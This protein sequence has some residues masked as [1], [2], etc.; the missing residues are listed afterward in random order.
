MEPLA[1]STPFSLE[2][3]M[4]R[5]WMVVGFLFLMSLLTIID[6]VCVSAAKAEM[7]ADL[8]IDD[9]RFG[10]VFSSFALGYALFQMPGGWFVDR[11]GARLFLTFVV[12]AWSVCTGIT[13]TV[14]ALGPL[15]VI[16]FV[17][18]GFEAGAYPAAARACY[19]WLNARQ[20]GVAQGILMSGSRL[21]AAFGL[22]IIAWVIER[23]GWRET[24]YVLG[25]VGLIWAA[26]WYSWF[27]EG[28][29]GSEALNHTLDWSV[30]RKPAVPGLLAQYFSSNFTIFLCFTWLLPYLRSR[31]GLAN[32]EA[33]FYASLP[34]YAAAT[35]NWVAGAVIDTLFR[36]GHP[37]NS[38][39]WPAMAGFAVS[40][41]AMVLAAEMPS[42]G[43]AVACFAAATFGADLALSPS[44]SAA[45]DIGQ[46]DTGLLSGA[47][48]MAGNIG[49][50]VSSLVFPLWVASPF[51]ASGYFYSAA[52]LNALAV[53]LWWRMK[54]EIAA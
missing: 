50:F 7:A 40:A 9:I 1:A 48:N 53:I 22:G 18:G 19:S 38:R 27:R 37:V 20:R 28:P 3:R 35:S 49:S 10:W 16:R 39:R 42:V 21:G 24:F 30:L 2:A 5:R 29:L 41:V 51:G 52:V 34:L 44:W 15:V 8:G 45:I 14:A 12:A 23:I 17:F 33:G 46:A 26:S 47:M 31:Y 32:A 11:R 43:W 25:G 4:S 13:G 36:R 6:R 54:W